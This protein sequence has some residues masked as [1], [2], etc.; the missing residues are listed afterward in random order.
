MLYI[1]KQSRF[2]NEALHGYL[3]ARAEKE[4]LLTTFL[5]TLLQLFAAHQKVDRITL[6]LIRT[7]GDILSS[8]AVLDSVSIYL[9]LV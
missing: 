6:P 9:L 8:S 1:V 4:E 2:T 3:S 7:V 5:E